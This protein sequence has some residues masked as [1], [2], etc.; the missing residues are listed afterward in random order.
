MRAALLR[1]TL[2]AACICLVLL[3]VPLA[4]WLAL[5][6]VGPEGGGLIVT[7]EVLVPLSVAMLALLF[8][9]LS[10]VVRDQ[11]RRIA[12][13]LVQLA[14]QA[15]RLGAGDTRVIP[16]PCGIAEIDA[17]SDVLARS[18]RKLL[19]MLSSE[20]QFAADA[21]HQLRTPLTALLMRLEEISMTDD[22]EVVREEAASAIEQ[23]ERLGDTVA[24]LL[25]RARHTTEAPQ[26]VRVNRVLA[27]LQRAWQPAYE[28]RHRSI[29]VTGERGVSVFAT[30]A[31]LGQIL[32]TLVE[33][34]LAH[35]DGTVRIE[36]R[37]SG[38]SIVIEV[39]D[40]G[41][42]VRPDLAPFVFDRG[43]STKSSGLGLG[44]A[45]D[46]AEGHGGRLELVRLH[47][48]LFAVFFSAV[49]DD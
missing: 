44:L 26:P 9:G 16:R 18:G 21:S 36:V 27:E 49:E 17:V 41:A 31:A 19:T 37:H 47:P 35:G 3:L 40:E 38:P 7:P 10:V 46:L 6:T 11:A 2:Y 5:R 43:Q 33:N 32:G 28:A 22:L 23:V 14:E 25:T 4:A 20:R 45:R 30:D 8:L 1:S 29:Q 48:V 34:S 15:E 39:S 13:P 12:D 42:G 24:T